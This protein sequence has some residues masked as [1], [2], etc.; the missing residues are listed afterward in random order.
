MYLRWRIGSTLKVYTGKRTWAWAYIKKSS[1]IR[2]RESSVQLFHECR[3]VR[4]KATFAGWNSLTV[5]KLSFSI[6]GFIPINA[7]HSVRN[8]DLNLQVTTV[9]QFPH[10]SLRHYLHI[11]IRKSKFTGN[12]IKGGPNGTSVEINFAYTDVK[13]IANLHLYHIF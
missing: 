8:A 1:R 9:T 6:T 4:C 2:E 3:H 5:L 11:P 10:F 12:K 13:V 7:L